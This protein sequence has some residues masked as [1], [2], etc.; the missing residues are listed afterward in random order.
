MKIAKFILKIKR[1]WMKLRLQP[2]RVFCFHQVSE[3]FD[4]S[5]MW[6]CDWTQI[7]QFKNNILHLRESGVEFISLPEAHEKLKNDKMR[8]KKYAVLTA[9][10][11]W[12]SMKNIIPW[13]VEQEI[14]ITLFVNSDYLDGKHY[15]TRVTEKLLTHQNI[16]E[17]IEKYPQIV[18]IASHGKTHIDASLLSIDDFIIE[19][20]AAEKIMKGY[21]KIGFYAFTYGH[22]TNQQLFELRNEGLVPVLVD[23]KKNYTDDG[24]IHR[25]CIDGQIIERAC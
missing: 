21:N 20:K 2:I 17:L 9:D 15:Q 19:V 10:D 8:C 5:T 24:V 16:I 14:P 4:K 1:K 3:V 12:A 18:T 23:G 22:Y 6:E 7:D 25:E 11:G 13:L